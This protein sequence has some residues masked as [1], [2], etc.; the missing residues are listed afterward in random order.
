M[1]WPA[2]AVGAVPGT[3]GAVAAVVADWPAGATEGV[4]TGVDW[5]AGVAA[6]RAMAAG[7]VAAGAGFAGSATSSIFK[8]LPAFR[9]EPVGA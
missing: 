6:R 1:A 5:F 4:A 8:S 9:A 7:A 2:A 3:A